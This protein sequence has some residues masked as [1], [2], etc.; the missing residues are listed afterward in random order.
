MRPVR[1]PNLGGKV[2]AGGELAVAGVGHVGIDDGL[3]ILGRQEGRELRQQALERGPIQVG[4]QPVV[5]RDRDRR[6]VDVELEV[7][8]LRRILRLAV[9]LAT[10]DVEPDDQPAHHADE[11][12]DDRRDERRPVHPGLKDGSPM[13][14]TQ[15]FAAL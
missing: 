13:I 2:I 7:H 1:P 8:G 14:R 4:E 3:Q 9:E 5:A 6:E 10:L 15:R 11:G 12:A